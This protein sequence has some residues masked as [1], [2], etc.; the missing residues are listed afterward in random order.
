MAVP[1]QISVVRQSSSKYTEYIEQMHL[2]ER[3]T[4]ALE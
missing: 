3:E 1:V 2:H 4:F